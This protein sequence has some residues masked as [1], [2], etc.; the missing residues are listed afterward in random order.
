MT[1]RDSISLCI[2]ATVLLVGVAR[3]RARFVLYGLVGERASRVF[4]YFTPPCCQ[5]EHQ[6]PIHGT[7]NSTVLF[8]LVTST[9][10]TTTT[11]QSAHFFEQGLK[12]RVLIPWVLTGV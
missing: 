11:S 7:P 5:S 2:Y 3:F 10:T 9:D 12:H 1:R 8:L 4:Q 6:R